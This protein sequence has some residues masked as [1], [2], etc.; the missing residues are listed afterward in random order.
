MSHDGITLKHYRTVANKQGLGPQST[1]EDLFVRE[2]EFDFIFGE[3]ERFINKTGRDPYILDVGCGNGYLLSVLRERFPNS[4]LGGIEFTPELFDLAI[5]RNL[6]DV[7]IINHDVRKSDFWDG[8]VD[9][10][11]TER[12]IINILSRKEQYRAI[13][14]IGQMISPGGLYIMI[15]S[16]LE[17]LRSLDKAREEMSMEHTRRSPQNKYISEA[18]VQKVIENNFFELEGIMPANYLSTHYYITRVLHKTIR[19]EGGRVKYTEFEKFFRAALPPS[20]GNYS[21]ILFRVFEKKD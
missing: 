3:I 8:P 9:I 15:E 18:A 7:K 5:S 4:K 2:K 11:I 10:I 13:K 1:M 19:P 21:P 6:T 12:V 16:F 20:I 14:N 17:P